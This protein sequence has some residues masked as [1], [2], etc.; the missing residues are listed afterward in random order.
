MRRFH[1]RSRLYLRRS[2]WTRLLLAVLILILAAFWVNSRLEPVVEDLTANEARA[3]AVQVIS[4][5]VE[6]SLAGQDQPAASMVDIQYKETGEIASLST[7]MAEMNSL[8]ASLLADVQEELGESVHIDL[9]VPIG[10]LLGG[11]LLHGRGPE[12][13]LR[14]TL[15]GNIEADFESEFTSAGINQTQH[16][17]NLRIRTTIYTFLAGKQGSAEVETTVPVAETVIVGE[18]PQMMASLQSK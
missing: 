18:V 15:S 11:G 3:R 7:D 16:I 2:A 9:G 12:V 13:P 5:A 10:T 14:I 4:A 1:R 17:V 8:K 6:E